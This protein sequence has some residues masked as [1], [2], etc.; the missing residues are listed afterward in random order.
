MTDNINVE[1][2]R[3]ELNWLRL[4]TENIER[5]IERRN[6]EERE[7]ETEQENRRGDNYP[8]NHPIVRD[9]NGTEIIIGDRVEFV[10]RGLFNT[11]SGIVYKISAS[12]TR[13]TSR[14]TLRRSVSRAPHNLRII[15]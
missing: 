9:I 1:E 6:E 12:G 14:D 15:H 11:T 13:V 4:A 7:T 5:I 10:T 2:L 3:E 8:H